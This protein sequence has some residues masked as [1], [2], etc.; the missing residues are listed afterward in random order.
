MR[1]NA[2]AEGKQQSFSYG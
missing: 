2:E 1:Q